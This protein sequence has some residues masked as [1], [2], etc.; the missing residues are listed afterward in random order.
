MR[1]IAILLGLALALGACSSGGD[2]PMAG[3]EGGIRFTRNSSFEN[4]TLRVF[5]TLPD[6]G[7]R[8]VDETDGN[9]RG[10]PAAP[11]PGHAAEEWDF[12][13][14]TAEG[15]SEAFA[16]VS[17]DADD[18]ADYLMM[19]WWLEFPDQW[20]DRTLAGSVPAAI[21]DGPE[22]DPSA[23]RELPVEGRATYNGPALGLFTYVP[24]WG[25]EAPAPFV[26]EYSGTATIEADFA[27]HTLSGRIGD[28]ATRRAILADSR[29]EEQ[30]A[31]AE[32]LSGYELHLGA[33]PLAPNGT[34][35]SADVTVE[36]LDKTITRSEGGWGGA[37]SGIPDG[38][39]NPR[40]VAG[41]HKIA[42]E[43]D[44]GSTGVF[45]GA[46]IAPSGNP[47]N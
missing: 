13:K 2:P 6:I 33:A 19:G 1:P 23:P 43:E 37:V 39:G 12:F 47:G 9:I 46:F 24:N 29:D 34:F 7:D 18:P 44:D 30:P 27:A 11:I 14:Q 16:L 21:V 10:R 38:A 45:H 4:R 35:E 36:H 20:R 28:F 17:Y 25:P 42:F 22:I 5:L 40:L 3:D 31:Y 41:A 26:E 8:S 15:T 32:F